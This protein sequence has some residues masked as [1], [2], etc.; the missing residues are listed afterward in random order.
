M[1]IHIVLQVRELND[2]TMFLQALG[3]FFLVDCFACSTVTVH[4]QIYGVLT[5]TTGKDLSAILK[6][7]LNVEEGKNYNVVV[8]TYSRDFQT[9]IKKVTEL[10]LLGYCLKDELKPHFQFVP[11]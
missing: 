3:F 7:D 4:V 1:F 5:S 8:K 9:S 11:Q 10:A 2:V 6:A